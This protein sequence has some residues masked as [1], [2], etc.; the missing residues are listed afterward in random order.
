MIASTSNALATL[1]QHSKDNLSAEQHQWFSSLAEVA[2]CEAG[3]IAQ[4][5]TTLGCQHGDKDSYSALPGPS[6]LSEIFFSLAAQVN[7]IGTLIHIADDAAY[8]AR[9]KR[10]QR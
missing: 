10:G 8:L 1:W 6:E 2:E 4:I 7:T 5:L 9:E 3:N